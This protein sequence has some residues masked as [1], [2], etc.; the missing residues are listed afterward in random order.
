MSK[1]V[2]QEAQ[3]QALAL[4]DYGSDAGAGYEQQTKADTTI[5]FI[6]LLQA[7]S[8]VVQENPEARAGMYY[9][10]V[11][12]QL[13]SAEKPLLFVPAT[14]RH[15]FSEWSPRG[16]GGG[17]HGHQPP[18]STLV[19][20]AVASAKQFGKNLTKSGTE[21]VETFYVYG[22][23][24]DDDGAG[25]S[26]AAIAFSSTKI[27]AYKSWMTRLRQVTVD[28]AG[29]KVHPPM[30]AHLCKL[31]SVAQKN[32]KGTFFVPVVS[33]ANPSG[34]RDSLLT[35]SDVRYQM[36][37]ACRDLVDSGDAKVDPS[38]QYAQDVRDDEVPF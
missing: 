3:N 14:T 25:G 17:F 32:D 33:A 20:E 7:M 4:Y 8:P 19:A 5:P 23:C 24:C 38:Q 6:A 13:W 18:S 27:K 31:T 34:L 12:G 9:N 11:S 2:K 10:T 16:E 35:P 28:V 21:L 36:A 1:L 30:F 15:L 29:A 26:F 37:K 22:I